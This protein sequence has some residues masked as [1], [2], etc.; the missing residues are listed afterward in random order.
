MIGPLVQITVMVGLT[1]GFRALERL[2]GPRR[3]GLLMG[4]P[5]TT[6]KTDLRSHWADVQRYD[7]WLSIRL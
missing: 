5:S 4:L 7:F 1:H 3:S 6:S 2:V